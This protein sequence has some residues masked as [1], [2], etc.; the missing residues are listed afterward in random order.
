MNCYALICC[1][2]SYLLVVCV[3]ANIGINITIQ[4]NYIR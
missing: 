1:I 2:I 3:N 4:S